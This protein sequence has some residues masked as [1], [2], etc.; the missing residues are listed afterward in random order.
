MTVAAALDNHGWLRVMNPEL[1]LAALVELTEMATLLHG[2]DLNEQEDAFRW[3]WS[4][5]GNFTSASAYA[6]FHGRELRP[7]ASEVWDSRAPS[8]CKVF[9]WLAIWNRCW[10]SDRLSRRGLPHPAKCPFCDQEQETLWTI[11]F[12]S[13]SLPDKFGLLVCRFG[14]RL[15][16]CLRLTT[17]WWTRLELLLAQAPKVPVAGGAL[18]KPQIKDRSAVRDE[19]SKCLKRRQPPRPDSRQRLVTVGEEVLVASAAGYDNGLRH[20]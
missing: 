2:V 19:I 4:S 9:M 14:E 7:G 8:K 16:G 3:K 18:C 10:T 12:F 20:P 6:S 17:L 11:F 13:V 5:S 15:I 1:P